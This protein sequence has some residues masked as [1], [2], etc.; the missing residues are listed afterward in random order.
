MM[1]KSK[2]HY[3]R[4]PSDCEVRAMSTEDGKK[5][6]SGLA[7]RFNVPTVL[8]TI[9]NTEYKE[10]ISPNALDGCD[11]SDVVLDRGHD[12]EGKL[13]ARTRSGT[14]RLSVTEEGLRYEADVPD[15]ELGRET[16]ELAQRGDLYGSS[17]AA[18][19]RED[20]FDR[21]THTR[22]ILRFER[23]YDVAAVTFPAYEATEVSA[24]LR[25]AFGIGED[26]KEFELEKARLLASY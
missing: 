11:L 26:R 23:F 2:L 24:E 19:I 17:F 15:T 22:T 13:L 7:L 16:Y 5:V 4:A 18:V 12:M 9:G 1:N 20:S 14:L 3:S 25:S 10:I 21:E 8:F 6:I